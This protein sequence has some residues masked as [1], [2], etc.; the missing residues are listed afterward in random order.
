MINL[1]R[2]Q[3]PNT[4]LR[5][6]QSSG[7][8]RANLLSGENQAPTIL[9]ICYISGICG[10]HCG[11]PSLLVLPI[12]PMASQE[13]RHQCL[14]ALGTNRDFLKTCSI[15]GNILFLKSPRALKHLEVVQG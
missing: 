2:A 10:H 4:A 3:V 13:P 8:P 7:V 14:S 9:E 15:P 1:C 5:A 6:L 11:S 12:L